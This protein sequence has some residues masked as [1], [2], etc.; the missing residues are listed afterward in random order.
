MQE[1]PSAAGAVRPAGAADLRTGAADLR[2]E[3]ADRLHSAAIHLLRTVRREDEATGLTAARLSALSVLVFGGARPLGEL[4]AAEQVRAPTMSR[5]VSALES[6]GL[7]TRERGQADGRVVRVRA[8]ARGRRVLEA[9]RARR[10]ARL[11]ELLRQAA[12]E[13]L[14]LL[15][16]AA[17]VVERIVAG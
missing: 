8:T 7:V 12:P 5:L 15:E 16:A 10:V 4:A 2:T 11:E 13:E 6:E 17:A 9:G 1:K 14:R 3:V